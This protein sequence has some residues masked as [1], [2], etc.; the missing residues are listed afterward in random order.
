MADTPK[1]STRPSKP[2]TPE[3]KKQE[4][5]RKRAAKKEARRWYWTVLKYGSLSVGG[6]IVVVL[7]AGT[8]YAAS[9]LKGLPTISANTF[10][11]LNQ[12]SVV[13]AR[14]GKTVIGRFDAQGNRDPITSLNQVSSNLTNSFIAAED[15]TFW[16]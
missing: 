3:Q 16:N 11:N 8:G 4:R 5:A 12:S 9:L 6:V 13:Y 1:R 14:D 15:K 2:Q 7:G 10:T